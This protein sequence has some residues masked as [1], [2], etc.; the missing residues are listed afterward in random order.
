MK[1][2]KTAF[3][4]LDKVIQLQ[5]DHHVDVGNS[6]FHK[7]KLR[8]MVLSIG[9]AMHDKLKQELLRSDSAISLI[10]DGST[11]LINKSSRSINRLLSFYF[12]RFW[13]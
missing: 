8:Q 9:D 2:L 3:V 10:V 6:C 5:R 1:H 12:C 4:N 11:G 13:P 7:D